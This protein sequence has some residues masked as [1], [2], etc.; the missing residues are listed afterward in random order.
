MLIIDTVQQKAK[1]VDAYARSPT[2]IAMP[3]A[4]MKS[5]A[6]RGNP[7]FT[8]EEKERF[9]NDPAYHLQYRYVIRT[10][11]R[12]RTLLIIQM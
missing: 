4:E 10:Q 2:W 5:K 6:P 12:K 9:K 8:E 1:H 11:R 7:R 3:F